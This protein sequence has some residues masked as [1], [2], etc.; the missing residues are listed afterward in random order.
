MQTLFRPLVVFRYIG[1]C[2]PPRSDGNPCEIC[3]PLFMCNKFSS[4][5]I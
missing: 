2:R 1:G 5:C 4:L 3:C